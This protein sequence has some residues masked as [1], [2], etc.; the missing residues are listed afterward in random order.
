MPSHLGPTNAY[1][2]RHTPDMLTPDAFVQLVSSTYD[3]S[4]VPFLLIPSPAFFLLLILTT[5]QVPSLGGSPR[6]TS[7]E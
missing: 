1:Q 2:L 5:F 3:N 7:L 4:C 6:S